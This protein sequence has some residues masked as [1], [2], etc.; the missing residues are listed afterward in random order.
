MADEGHSRRK[1]YNIH[2][3]TKSP[4]ADE[5]LRR[6]ASLDEIEATIRGQSAAQRQLV[7][8]QRSR[9]IVEAMHGWLRQQL[10]RVSGRS[11]LAKAIRHA[12]NHWKGLIQFLHD[13]R[14][15]LDTNIVERAMRPVALGRKNALFAG[16]PSGGQHWAIVAT[17]IQSARLND[18]LQRIVSA[19]TKSTEPHTLLPWNWKLE[20]P[21]HVFSSA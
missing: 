14:L 10:E 18:V 20:N 8:E 6:I 2:V 11:A 12:L 15:E 17:L 5:A 19:R 1:F 3:A 4:L 9:P 16:S 21:D 13:G 7:R